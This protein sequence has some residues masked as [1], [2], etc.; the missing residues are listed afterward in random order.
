MLLDFSGCMEGRRSSK[1]KHQ[2]KISSQKS[3]H[4][5]TNC[6]ACVL[7]VA[8]VSQC[9]VSFVPYCRNIRFFFFFF[10]SIISPSVCVSCRSYLVE[11]VLVLR[12]RQIVVDDRCFGHRFLLTLIIRDEVVDRRSAVGKFVLVHSLGRVPMQVRSFLQ[13]AVERVR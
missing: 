1:T 3:T 13:Q 11:S 5:P 12:H 9:N 8:R 10:F 2:S 4:S 6:I 7:I